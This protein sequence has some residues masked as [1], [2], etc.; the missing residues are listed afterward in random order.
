MNLYFRLLWV[1]LTAPFRGRLDPLATASRS[2]RVWP[3]DADVN[4]H[5]NNGRYLAVMDL[6]RMDYLIRIGG[7]WKVIRKAWFPVLAGVHIQYRRALPP[8]AKYQV[9]TRTVSWDDKWL[10]I[11]Q[12]FRH[13]GSIVAIAEVKAVFRS[14]RGLV[15]TEELLQL[16]GVDSRSPVSASSLRARGL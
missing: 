6:A 14:P 3:F 7:F 13:R 8:F 1:L 9:L 12:E 5:L 15:K 4:L 2:F 16:L 10:Y 11:A